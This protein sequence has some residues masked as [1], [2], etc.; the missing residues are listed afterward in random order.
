MD[1]IQAMIDTRHDNEETQSEL[2]KAL[3]WSR[4]QIARYETRK[5]VPSID[6]LLA[7]CLHYKI[8]AD[9]LLGLPKSCK[10]PRDGR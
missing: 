5:S 6:Y 2:A 7:F 3:K 10:S 4:P 8:S 1:Y 9:Y